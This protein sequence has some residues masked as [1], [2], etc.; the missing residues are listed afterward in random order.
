MLLFSLCPLNLLLQPQVMAFRWFI[1]GCG[2]GWFISFFSLF[3]F[4][5]ASISLW[6]IYHLILQ[7]KFLVD[8]VSG[9]F[10]FSLFVFFFEIGFCMCAICSYLL[11]VMHYFR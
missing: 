1:K 3:S 6:Q 2:S 10:I 9:F 4:V 11:H 7:F 5:F 8:K